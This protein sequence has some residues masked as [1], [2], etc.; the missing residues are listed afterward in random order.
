MLNKELLLT[1]G[2]QTKWHTKLTVG[3]GQDKFG[4]A[5]VDSAGFFGSMSRVPCWNLN[6]KPLAMVGLYGY[7]G[8]GSSFTYAVFSG[9]NYVDATEISM[10]VVEKG[11]TVTLQRYFE[12]YGGQNTM[13]F[14]SSDVGKT[15]TIVFDPEPTSYV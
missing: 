13:A 8:Y 3:I 7:N 4:Y 15:F 1:T 12:G 2:S 14:N 9:N 11:L 10:T 6:G 5:N